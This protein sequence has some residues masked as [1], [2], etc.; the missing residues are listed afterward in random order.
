MILP[1][2]VLAVWLWARYVIG[3]ALFSLKSRW[4]QTPPS[5]C[6]CGL[7]ELVHRKLFEKLCLWHHSHGFKFG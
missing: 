6:L 5:G 1:F 2:H 7:S 3:S 4:P